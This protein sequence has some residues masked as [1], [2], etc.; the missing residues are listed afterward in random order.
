MLDLGNE[1]NKENED[2]VGNKDNVENKD[3]KDN[4]DMKISTQLVNIFY[5]PR[6]I[7]GMFSFDTC[8]H[9]MYGI[10]CCHSLFTHTITSN[11][12][13]PKRKIKQ[14]LVFEN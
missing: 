9:S 6:V 10:L 2:N 11:L 14:I 5:H 13:Y 7:I 3:N 1:D 12:V 8:C 4:K